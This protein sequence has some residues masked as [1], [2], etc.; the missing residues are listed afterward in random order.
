MFKLVIV[1]L[2]L[3]VVIVLFS[4]LYFLMRDPD[5]SKR[6]VKALFI[7]VSLSA[8]LIAVIGF[9]IYNGSITPHSIGGY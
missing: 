6:T 7:R 4:G 1:I 9:G 3:L 8:L 5:D 2:F